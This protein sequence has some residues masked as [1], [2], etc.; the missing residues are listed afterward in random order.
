MSYASRRR[1]C[2]AKSGRTAKRV[3]PANPRGPAMRPLLNEPGRCHD[4]GS[5][6]RF[7]DEPGI[8]TTSRSERTLR[9]VV[10]ARQVSQ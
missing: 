9:P 1:G 4:A 7:L 10:I 3:A 5:L 6:V 8:E 2:Q